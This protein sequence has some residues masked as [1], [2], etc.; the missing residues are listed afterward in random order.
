MGMQT[1]PVTQHHVGG[2]EGDRPAG[3]KEWEMDGG[4]HL[5]AGTQRMGMRVRESL[6]LFTHSKL[7]LG[8]WHCAR[9]GDTIVNKTR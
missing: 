8:A 3:G 5:S 9:C 7:L 4:R 1:R 2:A 6:E